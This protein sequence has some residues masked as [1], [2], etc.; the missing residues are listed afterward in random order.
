M[1]VNVKAVGTT[2]VVVLDDTDHAV[3]RATVRVAA[4]AA[5][6]G[7]LVIV[8]GKEQAA[9]SHQQH[10]RPSTLPAMP[11]ALRSYAIVCA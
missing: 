2:N 1:W 8:R 10:S 7:R 11:T 6:I 4:D 9:P 3:F 5:E